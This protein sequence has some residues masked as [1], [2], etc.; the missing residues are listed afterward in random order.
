MHCKAE[1]GAVQTM[2]NLR[3]MYDFAALIPAVLFGL[4]ARRKSGAVFYGSP[5]LHERH[6][7]FLYSRSSG[8]APSFP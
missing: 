2:E 1:K 6:H 4:M 3:R 7:L 8:S 5:A